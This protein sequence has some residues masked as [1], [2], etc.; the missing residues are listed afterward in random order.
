MSIIT[1]FIPFIFL[2]LSMIRLQREP[3]PEGVIRLPGGKPVAV[4]LAS[5]GLITTVLTIIL[6]VIPNS[7]EPHKGAAVAKVIGSTLLLVGA[8]IVVFWSTSWLKRA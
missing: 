5:V 2:F 8:G 4:L 3:I 1:Y 6:A 7:D